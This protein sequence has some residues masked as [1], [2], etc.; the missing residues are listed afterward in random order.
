MWAFEILGEEGIGLD[1]SIFPVKHDL[2]GFPDA[3][4]F[5]WWHQSRNGYRIFEFPP[6]TIR[7]RNQNIGVGGGGYLRLIPYGVTHWAIHHLNEAQQQPAMVYFHPWEIDPDQPQIRA[8][9]RSVLR[10]YTNLSTMQVK[11]E[12]LL[13]DFH[14][15]PLSEVCNGH[16]AYLAALPASAIESETPLAASARAAG[17]R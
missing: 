12:R 6:S 7:Y 3:Q 13:Q 8:G 1:S 14:F 11:I 10:H 9:R 16:G 17:G 15:A 5:P 2:Y 4:R